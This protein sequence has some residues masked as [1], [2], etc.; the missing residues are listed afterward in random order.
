MINFYAPGQ[1]AAAFDPARCAELTR[2]AVWIDLLQ[3]TAE[4]EQN[5]ERVLGIDIPTRAELHEIELS[6]RLFEENGVLFMTT[7]VLTKADTSQ[8]E[9]SAVTFI[10]T[11]DK[12]VT[13]R[14]ADPAPFHAFRIKRDANPQRFQTHYQIFGGLIDAIIERIADI[15]EGVGANLDRISLRVFEPTGARAVPHPPGDLTQSAPGRNRKARQRDFVEI[16][17]RIGA[18]SDLVS[19]ARESL[20]SLSRLVTF[21]REVGKEAGAAKEALA[22][23][24]TLASDLASLSDHASFLSSKVSFLL[25]ATLGMINNEQNAIIKILSVA[26]LVFLPPTLVAGIYGMNF[27]FIPELKW[28]QGYPFA[29]ALMIISAVLPY[30]FFRRKGWL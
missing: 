30:F 20:V 11:N 28:A 27:V 1:P 10:V 23:W 5:L 13:V 25:D 18:A 26:A 22:H 15:L 29:L 9:S 12:L 2:T 16:L 4:E 14:Y 8:P 7:T 17:R 19:R 3:P 6:S 24:K 21:F